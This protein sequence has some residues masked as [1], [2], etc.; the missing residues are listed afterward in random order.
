MRSYGLDG[1][2]LCTVPLDWYPSD[3]HQ[4]FRTT[5]LIN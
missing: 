4:A 1:R 2:R 5:K 3:V